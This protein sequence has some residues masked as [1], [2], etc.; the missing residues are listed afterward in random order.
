MGWVGSM[1]FRHHHKIA[2]QKRVIGLPVWRRRVLLMGLLLG[3]VVLVV[4]SVYLQSTKKE[5]LQKQGGNRYI[6]TLSLQ[7]DRGKIT[8]RNGVILA[9]SSPVGSVWAN[10]SVV[11]MDA[12]EKQALASLLKIKT[13]AL[14]EKLSNKK[15]EFVYIKRRLP[16]SL[17][18]EVKALKIPGI[19]VEREY[20]RF[21][22]AGNVVSH[23][24]GFTGI[25]GGGQEGVE[26]IRN[27]ELT[28]EAG[29]RRVIKDR[30]G[31]IV[32][33]LEVVNEPRD[34]EELA[35]S[36]D[37]RI[38]YLVFRELSRS[39][40]KYKAKAGSAVVLDAKTGEVVVKLGDKIN[41]LNA[42][43]LANDGLKDIL[44]SRES[45]FANLQSQ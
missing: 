23:V 34:G 38:Q 17:A 41:F 21:Y 10:P 14:G 33:E 22:P 24:V 20:K 12:Q 31:H 5:F 26:L 11:K 45:L 30:A 39:V 6:R 7:A 40:E 2:H 44:V 37:R 27:A 16:P 15:R 28:G 9:G 1:E 35:L 4:Q 43:K 3:F 18:N 42:K 36:I 19:Y 29:Q 25:D 32:E 13:T 8:D